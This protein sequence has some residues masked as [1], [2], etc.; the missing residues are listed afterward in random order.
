MNNLSWKI[1]ELHSIKPSEFFELIQKNKDYIHPTFPV[2]VAFCDS[3]LKTKNFFSESRKIKEQEKGD[4]FIIK[5]ANT[6]TLIGYFQIKNITE[7]LGRCEFAYFIDQDFQGIGIVSAVISDRIV[8]A[9]E[10][11]DLNKIVICT[12]KENLASQRVAIKNNFQQEGI[13]RN[14]FMNY[15]GEL[16]DVMY[17]GLL[18][19]EFQKNEK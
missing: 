4:Y 17:F 2:T 1:A 15:L 9:F 3:L 19:S 7:K 10:V 16:E 5:K 6:N 11:L 14:E 8:H 13:L 12:S 18:K